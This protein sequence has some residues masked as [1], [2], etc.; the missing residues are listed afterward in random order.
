MA[1]ARSTKI[2]SMIKWIRTSRKSITNSFSWAGGAGALIVA[3][4]I[5]EPK[6][7][8][9]VHQGGLWRLAHAS[10]RHAPRSDHPAPCTLHPAPCTL[11]PAPCTLHPAPCT[12]HPATLSTP[13]SC[14]LIELVMPLCLPPITPPPPPNSYLM[15]RFPAKREQLKKVSMTLTWQPR[16]D[17]QGQNR[18][19]YPRG[20][21]NGEADGASSTRLSTTEAI[22]TL[23]LISWCRPFGLFF[24][25]C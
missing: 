17:S 4:A 22:S 5:R 6:A 2:I 23:Y 7:A 18:S 14:A 21:N 8:Q 24:S 10:S 19:F 9:I 3:Q 11:H 15:L 12:L 20:T 13:T 1:Q 25:W 16:P